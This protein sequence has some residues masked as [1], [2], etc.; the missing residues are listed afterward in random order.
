MRDDLERLF[1]DTIWAPLALA[2]VVGCVLFVL[3]VSFA[4]FVTAALLLCLIVFVVVLG[5][6]RAVRRRSGAPG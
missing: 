1:R 4:G 6:A 5:G 3:A 2:L